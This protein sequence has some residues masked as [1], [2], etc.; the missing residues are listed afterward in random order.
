MY[1]TLAKSIMLSHSISLQQTCCSADHSCY[2]CHLREGSESITVGWGDLSGIKC[3]HEEEGDQYN[4]HVENNTFNI[5]IIKYS[6]KS[7]IMS[8]CLS[9]LNFVLFVGGGEGVDSPLDSPY[10]VLHQRDTH[11]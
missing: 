1:R 6:N 9:I 8:I 10:L 5:L 7:L 3:R 11:I 2:K 4:Q